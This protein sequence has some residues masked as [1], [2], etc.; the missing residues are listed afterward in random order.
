M[1]GLLVWTLAGG[2]RVRPVP[3]GVSEGGLPAGAG[4]RRRVHRGRSEWPWN[5]QSGRRGSEAQGEA[6]VMPLCV[7][8]RDRPG[9]EQVSGAS[10]LGRLVSSWISRSF[11]HAQT[12]N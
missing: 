2:E 12:A 9:W 11:E 8:G 3:Q 10:A 5:T 1:L 6:L 4:A 7:P